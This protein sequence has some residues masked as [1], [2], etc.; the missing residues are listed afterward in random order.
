MLTKKTA[1]TGTYANLCGIKAECLEHLCQDSIAINKFTDK[2]GNIVF[3]GAVSDGCSEAISSEYGSAFIVNCFIT[4]VER[5]SKTERRDHLFLPRIALS[6]A[7][8]M[9]Q[10]QPQSKDSDVFDFNGISLC[11]ELVATVYGFVADKDRVLIMAAGDGFLA[12][13]GYGGLIDQAQGDLYP[14][15]LLKFPKD[16][17]AKKMGLYYVFADYPSDQ[18]NSLLLATD[19]FCNPK[20]AN[21]PGLADNPAMF[22]L[23]AEYHAQKDGTDDIPGAYA[24]RGGDDATLLAFAKNN[25]ASAN[26]LNKDDVEKLMKKIAAHSN[27]QSQ[28]ELKDTLGTVTQKGATENRAFARR[29]TPANGVHLYGVTAKDRSDYRQEQNKILNTRAIRNNDSNPFCFA[30]ASKPI[31]V[32]APKPVKA[33]APAKSKTV[34]GLT[35][36]AAVDPTPRQVT[37]PA[38][39]PT[40]KP[41]PKKASLSSGKKAPTK[42]PME[43]RRQKKSAPAKNMISFQDLC[44]H[45]YTKT[46]GIGFRHF[47]RIMFDL[48]HFVNNCHNQGL[49]IGNL[50]P[51]DLNVKIIREQKSEKQSETSA[52][53]VFSLANK[54]NVAHIVK[55]GELAQNYQNLDIDFVHPDYAKRLATDDQ[56]RIDQDWYAY[57][58]LCCWLVTKSDPFGEGVVI[59]QPAADRIYRMRHNIL[60]S[61]SDVEMDERRR[62]FIERATRRVGPMARRYIANFSENRKSNESPDFLLEKFHSNNIFI[63]E[64]EI[65]KRKKDGETKKMKCGFKQLRGFNVCCYCRSQQVKLISAPHQMFQSLEKAAAD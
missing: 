55:G 20:P 25:S 12:I 65:Y 33:T 28:K 3:T 53:F 56:A 52:T 35:P 13:N 59:D 54:E 51:C 60:N 29:I 9:A 47:G 23:Q 26:L 63:C 34:F 17:W 6:L 50:R 43:I 42:K 22:V 61:S 38:P 8:K 5:L 40:S 37:Q 36:K 62:V 1:I 48:W 44:G 4:E 2:D 57:S 10:Y 27:G 21:Y 24:S 30:P 31:R 39:A 16:L 45:K 15:N 49:R 7:N 32:T 64:A 11:H 14:V 41:I 18:I 19:G 46:K 58:V